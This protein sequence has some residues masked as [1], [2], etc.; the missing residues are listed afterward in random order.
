MPDK[1]CQH[2]ARRNVAGTNAPFTVAALTVA[3]G[4]VGLASGAVGSSGRGPLFV[5]TFTLV[6]ILWLGF[7]LFVGY[8]EARGNKVARLLIWLLA[9]ASFLG[10]GVGVLIM[11]HDLVFEQR[12]LVSLGTSVICL[13]I[14][15]SVR[16]R[17]SF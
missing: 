5:S 17:A 16:R 8:G 10:N 7:V 14:A 12:A 6:G 9:A 15:L 2:A 3:A 13:V 11:H 1:K 4:L